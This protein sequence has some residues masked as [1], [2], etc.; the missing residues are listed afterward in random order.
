MPIS[1]F[2]DNVQ[3]RTAIQVCEITE[4]R[5][6]ILFPVKKYVKS[7]V[8]VNALCVSKTLLLYTGLLARKKAIVWGFKNIIIVF[9]LTSGVF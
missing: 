8:L 9:I 6:V 2:F 1:I 5:V 7:V 4:L 3:V